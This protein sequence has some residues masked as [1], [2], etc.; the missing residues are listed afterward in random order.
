MLE[1]RDLITKV[2]DFLGQFPIVGLL[3]PRQVGKTTISRWVA[4]LARQQNQSVH[5]F[6]L[7]D[8]A[9]L[10]RL[11]N[12]KLNLQDLSGLIIIDEIQRR[13]EL[14]PVL[15][16]LADRTPLRSRFL[17]LGSAS[18]ELIRQS[19]ESLAGRIGYIDVTPF[20][21]GEIE[22]LDWRQ[23]WVRGG[24]PR[25]FLARNDAESQEWREQY[26]RTFLE[27]DIPQLGLSVPAPVL[28]R[29]W[30]M[31]AHF[32]GQNI[33]YSEIS[34]SMDVSD[35][36]VRRYCDILAGTF[37]VRRLQPWFENIA[38]RQVKAPKIYI[39]DSGLFHSLI[40]TVNKSQLD[41]H[42]K[43]GASWEGFAQEEILKACRLREQDAFFWAVH[44]QGE[45]DLLFFRGGKKYGVEF[46]YTDAPK[47]TKSMRLAKELL[48]LDKLYLVYPGE[49][50]FNLDED[51]HALGLLHAIKELS[52]L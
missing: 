21:M 4:D 7:E 32:H 12:A 35:A 30:M 17:I 28:R 25:S 19:T 11:S 5:T 31:I 20:G 51:V 22:S 41:A 33:N 2:T 37:M 38:K 29:F 40:G 1:R 14:F 24:Y 18:Q 43:L 45:I 46:K 6:D 23:L 36:T 15:R 8:P 39:R 48:K 50:A 42:P 9:D 47:M 3:G 26:I 52:L 10:E 44:Q 34:R 27:R 13:P 49:N 16:V